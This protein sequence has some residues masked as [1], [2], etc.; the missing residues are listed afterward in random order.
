[1]ALRRS[2]IRHSCEAWRQQAVDLGIV[3]E[4]V[5]VAAQPLGSRVRPEVLVAARQLVVYPSTQAVAGKQPQQ[6]AHRVGAGAGPGHV[7]VLVVLDADQHADQPTRHPGLAQPPKGVVHLRPLLG[8]A[9][10][11][12]APARSPDVLT[13]LLSPQGPAA[14]WRT[15]GQAAGL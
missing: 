15:G 2:N 14:S 9:R 7:H 11:L 3:Y 1:M 13:L 6:V 8:A 5:E 12:A 4:V 10:V